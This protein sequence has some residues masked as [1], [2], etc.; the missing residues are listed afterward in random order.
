[1][2]YPGRCFVTSLLLILLTVPL[3]AAEHTKDSLETV[4]ENIAKKKAVLLDV[5]EISEWEEGHLKGAINVPLSRL[6]KNPDTKWLEEKI[7]AKRIVYT[8]CARGIRA[9]AAGKI[10]KKQGYKVRCLKQ[11]YQELLAGPF[12]Q[13]EK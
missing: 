11:G 4:K 9:L 3:Q 8:H 2:R 12:E 6:M 13:A 5:R 7:P 1:M 10:L